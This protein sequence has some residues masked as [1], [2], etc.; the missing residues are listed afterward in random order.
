[1]PRE[2]FQSFTDY[3]IPDRYRHWLSKESVWGWLFLLPTLAALGLVSV[4]PIL[5]GISMSFFQ[6]D[7]LGN[8]T[9]VGLSNYAQVIELGEFWFVLANTIVWSFVSVVAMAAIGLFFALLLNRDFR[10]KSVATTLLLLPWAVPFIAIAL[11][12]RLLYSYELGAF[13]GLLEL[14]GFQAVEWLGSSRYALFSASL[15]WVWRNF[16]FF[17]ITFL[18]AM[19][20]IPNDLYEAARIDGSSRFDL[21]RH[22]TIPFLQPI[23]V[24]TTLLMS[25]WTLNHFTIIYVMTSGG[26]GTS[27]MVLPV[28]IY[29]QAFL[30]NEIGMAAAIAVVMLLLMLAYGLFYL[31]FYRRDVG[32]A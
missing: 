30:Q 6:Y 19:K 21:F 18:A 15:T 11:N 3:S 24:V 12:W 14:F 23:T 20:G 17:M 16:P 27:S 5:R 8:R 26:P 4:Y 32:G 1:M 31:R 2:I 22:I 10:G 13:N 9:W 7:I 28:Y 29:Q 25:L